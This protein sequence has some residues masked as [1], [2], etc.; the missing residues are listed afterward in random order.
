MLFTDEKWRVKC[1][2]TRHITTRSR[3]S[4]LPIIQQ[5][6]RLSIWKVRV[7]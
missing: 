6:G 1:C 5:Q 3:E 7:A 2:W 4:L